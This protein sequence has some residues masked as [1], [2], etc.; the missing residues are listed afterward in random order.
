MENPSSTFPRGTSTS[1]NVR[2]TATSGVI[3]DALGAKTA[4]KFNKVREAGNGL[5][6]L[7]V[8]KHVRD[9]NRLFPCH[10]HQ[11]VCQERDGDVE[12]HV[13]HGVAPAFAPG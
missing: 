4:L 7:S 10:P 5:T 1:Y 9:L 6:G 11:P 13:D 8:V 2:S 3:Y 12:L